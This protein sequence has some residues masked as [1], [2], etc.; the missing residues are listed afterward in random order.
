MPKRTQLL[1]SNILD[2]NFI[3]KESISFAKKTKE[4]SY[5]EK[6]D[7]NQMLSKR[8]TLMTYFSKFPAKH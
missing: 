8:Y 1:D 3:L 5:Q 2:S 6:I 7:L 4:E